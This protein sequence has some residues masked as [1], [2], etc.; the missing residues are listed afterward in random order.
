M[1]IISALLCWALPLFLLYL[2]LESM[3]VSTYL[4]HAPAIAFLAL[5]FFLWPIAVRWRFIGQHLV[6]GTALA[7]FVAGVAL[8]LSFYGIFFG[9]GA[10]LIA[11]VLA[12]IARAMAH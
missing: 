10:L 5:L 9:L 3:K 6:G 4:A 1:K 8:V 7:F 2:Q 12:V 11:C